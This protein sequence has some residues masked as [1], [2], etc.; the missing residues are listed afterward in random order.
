L[1]RIQPRF[2]YKVIP[3]HLG[4]TLNAGFYFY[5]ENAGANNKK[6]DITWAVQPEL[7]WTF[8]GTGALNGYDWTGPFYQGG[9]TGFIV[10]YR[11]VSAGDE[12]RPVGA[13]NSGTAIEQGGWYPVNA[14]DVV[15]KFNF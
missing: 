4:F 5:T 15:F 8:L 7:F 12:S 10:R 6:T 11:V 13:F 14:L 3:S 1:L 2:S 9:C